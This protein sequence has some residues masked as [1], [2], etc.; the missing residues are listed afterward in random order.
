[1]SPPGPCGWS[2]EIEAYGATVGAILDAALND[3]VPEDA[4]RHVLGIGLLAALADGHRRSRW[5][6][7]PRGVRVPETPGGV[8]WGRRL[9]VEFA[10][11]HALE[12]RV[13]IEG[14]ADAVAFLLRVLSA[15][16]LNG[17]VSPTRDWTTGGLRESDLVKL[18]DHGRTA[19]A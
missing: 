9:G 3:V 15:S 10:E 19:D 18:G 1:V 12:V 7:W 6:A 17:R 14:P 2:I 11:V 8:K 16:L 4:A 13:Y 5:R